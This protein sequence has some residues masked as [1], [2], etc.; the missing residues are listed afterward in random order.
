MTIP[1]I[2]P[3]QI[4]SDPSLVAGLILVLLGPLLFLFSFVKFLRARTKTD[5]IVPHE[6]EEALNPPPIEAPAPTSEPVRSAG[7]ASAMAP[8][9][10]TP[11]PEPERRE[12]FGDKTVVLPPYVSELQA[13]IEIAVSQ[14]KHMNKKIYE[15]EQQIEKLQMQRSAQLDDNELKEPP[16][17]PADF[18]KK[19]LKVV[20]HVIV[21][22]KEVSQLRNQ[23]G[24][25]P[26]ASPKAPEPAKP[27]PPPSLF[28]VGSSEPTPPLGT[29]GKPPIMPL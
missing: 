17:D 25:R 19:L 21:L 8:I 24:V 6:D 26:A 3:N 11:A 5:F 20:E 28:D 29:G 10:D 1:N 7:P 27:A 15:V 16:M 13:Q 12:S 14:V 2:D 9:F 18:T 23:A 22:E 4:L